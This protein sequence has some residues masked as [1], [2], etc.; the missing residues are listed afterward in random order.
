ML[1]CSSASAALCWL[2]SWVL[3]SRSDARTILNLSSLPSHSL[4]HR[5]R[6][7]GDQG[8][9]HELGRGLLFVNPCVNKVDSF[10][11]KDTPLAG[12]HGFEAS[13]G[14]RSSPQ[15]VKVSSSTFGAESR[16][17]GPCVRRRLEWM[18][19][20]G[21]GGVYCLFSASLAP[22]MFGLAT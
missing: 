3:L 12:C 20:G 8:C 5:S 7:Q 14:S 10:L 4:Q 19:W 16:S 9:G 6:I 1:D 13:L 15:S 22:F 18:L 11:P 2:H 17:I 21:A